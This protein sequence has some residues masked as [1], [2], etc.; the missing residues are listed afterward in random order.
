MLAI[1][2]KSIGIVTIRSLVFL[3]LFISSWCYAEEQSSSA[4][5]NKLIGTWQVESVH[6]DTGATRTL[7][8]QFN[9]PS[10]IGRMLTVSADKLLMNTPG[11]KMCTDPT[12]SSKLTTAAVLIKDTMGGRGLPPEIPTP[13]D[14]EL[15]L[16]SQST[17]NVMWLRCKTG[18]FGADNPNWL[19]LLPN[20]QLAVDWHDGAILVFKRLPADVKPDPSFNCAKATIP[21]EKTICG[22]I[23][24]A[25]FDRSVAKSYRNAITFYKHVENTKGLK[26]LQSEQKK[27]LGERNACKTDIN[28]LQKSMEERLDAIDEGVNDP[29]S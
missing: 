16:T 29:E 27:W 22:S 3:I 15:P 17:V 18:G 25:A 1:N 13:E 12:I 19:L 11:H 20:G 23:A 6:V 9:D 5:I 4:Q 7:H 10:L 8:V 26:R 14:Y 2:E 21:A 24:L 28:C